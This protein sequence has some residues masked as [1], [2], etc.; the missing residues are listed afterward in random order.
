VID[1]FTFMFASLICFVVILVVDII[2]LHCVSIA[3][4]FPSVCRFIFNSVVCDV[5]ED[6]PRT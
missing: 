5:Y 3:Y 4:M 6:S 2:F 1:V